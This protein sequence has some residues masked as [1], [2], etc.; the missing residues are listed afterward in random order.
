MPICSALSCGCHGATVFQLFQ[1]TITTIKHF[2]AFYSFFAF[3]LHFELALRSTLAVGSLALFSLARWEEWVSGGV[4]HRKHRGRDT[5]CVV[6][7]PPL[8]PILT[9]VLLSASGELGRSRWGVTAP[10]DETLAKGEHRGQCE[11]VGVSIGVLYGLRRWWF[12][13]H[14][15][16]PHSPHPSPIMSINHS[17]RSLQLTHF[18]IYT[19]E[20]CF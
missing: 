3:A 9:V 14:T 8:A 6:F 12:S 10:R 20:L 4:L 1:H 19:L 11:R 13:L 16:T 15:S 2:K 18:V 5:I 17:P 7:Q